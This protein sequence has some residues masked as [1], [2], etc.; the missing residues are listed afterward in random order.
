MSTSD[1]I[2]LPIATP[3]LRAKLLA[4]CVEE[5]GPLET[6]CWV[7]TRC[8]TEKGYGS[9]HYLGNTY[10]AHRLAYR[11]FVGPF[12]EELLVCH[13][14]D[15]PACLRA[16]HLYAGPPKQNT[17][18]MWERGPPDR[19]GAQNGRAILTDEKVI[20]ILKL[21]NEGHSY[22]VVA[23][24]FG[25]DRGIIGNIA[26]GK[27]WTHIPGP[28]PKPRKP[29]SAYRGVKWNVNIKKWQADISANGKRKH[30]GYFNTEVEAG[31]AYN[32]AVFVHGLDRPLNPWPCLQWATPTVTE[33]TAI[34]T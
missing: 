20:E 8:R 29:S 13:H 12:D 15:N 21:L 18:D 5:D 9:I 2:P 32:A 25:V 30:L 6:P 3:E 27:T 10:Q 23:D 33:V 31:R 14:C 22:A 1:H 34:A 4:N 16:E 28:R 17:D 7:W 24:L 11:C 19:K 26:T